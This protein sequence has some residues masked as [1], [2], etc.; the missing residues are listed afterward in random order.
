MSVC[1][2]TNLSRQGRVRK[3]QND[4]IIEIE[5]HASRVPNISLCKLLARHA[6]QRSVPRL[7]G[8]YRR[9]QQLLGQEGMMTVAVMTVLS[10]LVLV[11]DQQRYH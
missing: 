4:D 11:S 6:L 8:L 9:F 1:L 5:E 7:R 3:D 2:P 10:I